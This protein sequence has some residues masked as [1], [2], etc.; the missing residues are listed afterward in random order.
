P[1][2][3]R[4]LGTPVLE[5]RSFA[6]RDDVAAAKV[7]LINRNLA[8][9]L[10]P[11][12]SAVGKRLQLVNSEQSNEWREIVGVVGD[13]RYSGLDDAGA[14]ANH[15]PLAKPLFIGSYLM[16]RGG[17]PPQTLAQ[18]VRAAVASTNSTL[19]VV[20][21]RAMDQLISETVAQPRFNTVLLG[22][23]ALLALAL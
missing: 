8:R 17:S 5:G 18:S 7:L 20:N 2:Y 4:A 9:A 16:I 13:V 22:A 10:F 11:N 3:L 15:P 21:F 12:E 23:F 6:D 19:Q 1:D 14:D